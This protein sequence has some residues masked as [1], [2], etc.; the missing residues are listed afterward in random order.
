MMD[1]N[2][3][4]LWRHRDQKLCRTRAEIGKAGAIRDCR[5]PLY[6]SRDSL[7]G[8]ENTFSTESMGLTVSTILMQNVM[9]AWVYLCL[10][11]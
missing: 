7:R 1:I 11:V 4:T 10:T 6:R 5:D 8:G 2:R 3:E 9:F